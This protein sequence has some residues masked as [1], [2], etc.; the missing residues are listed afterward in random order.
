MRALARLS[1]LLPEE[2]AK[3]ASLELLAPDTEDL[4]TVE[5]LVS[6]AKQT[7]YNESVRQV[8]AESANVSVSR[9]RKRKNRRKRK[10]PLPQNASPERQ[11]DP[12]R[13]IPKKDRSNAVK[14][15]GKKKREQQ[16][17]AGAQQAVSVAQAQQQYQPKPQHLQ[18][19]SSSGGPRRGGRKRNR[20]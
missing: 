19:A 4:L 11:T 10:K 9:T 16:K 5:E 20:K 3:E 18:E 15:K 17:G 13:W 6:E 1:I 14:S 12:E 7:M 2:Q 8:A